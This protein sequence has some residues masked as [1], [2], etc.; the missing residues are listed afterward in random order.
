M[1]TKREPWGYTP[2]G[3]PTQRPERPEPLAPKRQLPAFRHEATHAGAP[4]TLVDS[5]SA[6]CVVVLP[7]KPPAALRAAA[8]DLVDAIARITG[9]RVPLLDEKDPAVRSTSAAIILGVTAD[10][11]TEIADRVSALPPEGFLLRTRGKVIHIAGSNVGQGGMP[12]AGTAHGVYDFIERQLGV[13]WLWPGELG[14]VFPHR[15]TLTVPPLDITDAPAFAI[16]KLRNYGASSGSAAGVGQADRVTAG[17]RAIG[18]G[19][20]AVYAAKAAEATPWF[21]RLRLGQSQRVNFGHSYNDYAERFATNHPNWF[22][23]Q[24][25]GTRTPSAA[26]PRLNKENPGLIAQAARDALRQFD[27][28][29]LLSIASLTPNDGG[30]SSWDLD[31]DARALDPADGPPVTLPIRLGGLRASLPYVSMTDRILTFYNG[32]AAE[33]NRL[34]PGTVLGASAY[35]MYRTPPLR[36]VPHPQLAFTFV[37]LVYFDE[38]SRQRDRRSWDGW[39]AAGN[40]LMLRPNALYSGHGLPGVFVTKLAEDLRHCYE[41]MMFGADFDAIVHNWASQGLNYYV[42]AKLLW[43]PAADVPALIDDYCRTG[44]GPAASEVKSYF[45]QLE[46]LTNELANGIAGD[47]NGELRADEDEPAR[48]LDPDSI[49]A[50]IPKYYSPASLAPLRA[51]LARAAVAAAGDPAVRGRVA[52]LGRGLDY[53]EQQAKVFALANARPMDRPRLAAALR[54]RQAV[55]QDIYDR[56]YFA[57]GFSRVLFKEQSVSALKTNLPR[58]TAP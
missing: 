51:T 13:R 44:F 25:D 45:T 30:A 20:L 9:V 54:E 28:D 57:I 33:V 50:V 42:L 12:L 48:G 19:D 23:L 40:P 34:R 4:L 56:D 11:P 53:A 6:G 49:Y 18:R 29:P 1:P 5:S 31:A 38:T 22:A 36:T 58:P 8:A 14:T 32:V 15:S 26:R 37:G 41:T 27:A 52:F 2:L 17:L 7:V 10:T 47:I 55:F 16:R 43:N 21:A 46:S 39:A 35:S 3:A 24:P